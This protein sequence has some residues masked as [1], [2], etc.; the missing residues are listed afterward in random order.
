M[1][2]KPLV[3]VLLLGLLFLLPSFADAARDLG[4]G[5]LLN[6]EPTPLPMVARNLVKDPV[7]A[8]DPVGT[9]TAMQLGVSRTGATFCDGGG[10]SG[11]LGHYGSWFFGDEFYAFYQDPEE[12]GS[13]SGSSGLYTFDVTAINW[14]IVD[15][16][17]ASFIIDFQPLTYDNATD[18]I[19]PL[20]GA[21]LCAGPLYTV[22][23]TA[24]ADGSGWILSFPFVDQCCVFG[25][26]FAGIYVPTV[27]GSG[28]LGIVIDDDGAT[29]CWQYNDYGG[30]FEDLTVDWGFVGDIELWSEGNAYDQN[31]CPGL[32]GACDYKN[33]RTGTFGGESAAHIWNDPDPVN[34]LEDYYVRFSADVSCTLM[35]MRV[36]LYDFNDGTV[37]RVRV[38]GDNWPGTIG[39]LPIPDLAP[40]GSNMEGYVDVPLDI[41]TTPLYPAW[42]DVDL[43]SLGPLEYGTGQ[44]FF[45]SVTTSPTTPDPVN[46]YITVLTNTPNPSPDPNNHSGAFIGIFGQYQTFGQTFGSGSR[47]LFLDAYTCC[48]IVEAEE[49]A[50]PAAGPDQ[51]ATWAHDYGRTSASTI[52][53]GAPCEVVADWFANL[54]QVNSFCE[55]TV[56]NDRVYVSSDQSTRVFD[57]GTGALINA[58]AGLPYIFSS[59]RGNVTVEGSAAYLTGGTGQSISSWDLD[60]TAA[61]WCNGIASGIGALGAQN[62][63]GAV[64]V[65]DAG[66]TEIVVVGT[67]G[68]RLWAYE[69]AT[70]ALFAGWATNPLILDQGIVHGTAYDG[71]GLYVATASS[72]NDAGSVYRLDPLT[73]ATVWNVTPGAAEAFP[74]G[75]SL[76]ADAVY[77]SSTDAS[78]LGHRYKLAKAD[79]STTWGF[80]QARSLYGSPAIGRNFIYIGQDIGGVGVIAVDKGTGA[81]IH[82]FAADGVGDVPQPVTITCDN[83]VFAG[84]REG[85]WWL[86]DVN[87][88]T[89]VWGIDVPNFSIVNGTALATHSG[90]ATTMPS[91][92]SVRAVQPVPVLSTRSSSTRACV[93]VWTSWSTRRQSRSNS[94]LARAT[95]PANLMSSRTAVVPTWTS[96]RSISTTRCRIR[97]PAPSVVSSPTMRRPS[98][99]A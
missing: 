58:V 70:G 81:P 46:D 57:L 48:E 34:G 49:V 37:M 97:Q 53:V 10:Q 77:L 28:V 65:Y 1:H 82:N 29:S 79:G 27:T 95:R 23:L 55:P 42:L 24:E 51:W 80:S 75:L 19:C 67:E 64:S 11:A 59:N 12:F 25:P 33:P 40:G 4:N 22:D 68:G 3:A 43:T 38:Y 85:K 7:G 9:P 66:G 93:R 90:V 41:N 61:N 44:T 31:A 2:K 20:P 45:V 35:S 69:A 13:C 21:V 86:L 15:K 71:T 96:T 18:N 78:N 74:A 92:A 56:A 87:T 30:G 91:S 62:R 72:A 76:D 8:I 89:A 39:G 73:G 94:A 99:P 6:V 54:P 26:Y 5:G 63:F 32:P 88:L 52:D 17:S 47:E 84:D 16:V 14:W 60:L 50:C 98:R 83:Y 36:M